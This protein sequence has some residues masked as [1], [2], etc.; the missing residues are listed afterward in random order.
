MPPSQTFGIEAAVR[1]T[2]GESK[3]TFVGNIG[4]ETPPPALEASLSMVGDW[5]HPFG[6]QGV[7]VSNLAAAI[8]VTANAPWINSLGLA[9]QLQIGRASLALAAFVVAG[10]RNTPPLSRVRWT[11]AT[12]DPM[13]RLP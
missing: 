12:I 5:K 6:V 8:G 1:V 9:G 4:I 10:Y 7:V 2:I 13:Y 3:L 11:S